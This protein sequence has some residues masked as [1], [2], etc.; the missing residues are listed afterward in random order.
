MSASFVAAGTTAVPVA[1]P[2]R[3]PA[4]FTITVEN[5]ADAREREALLDR[6]M[7]EGRTRKSS[8]KLRHQRLPAE[9]LALVARD[10]TGNM[11]GTVRLWHISAGEKSGYH[12]VPA[13]LLGPLA[14]EPSYA[15]RGVGSALMRQ[16]ISTA[17]LQGHKAILLVGDPEYYGRFGFQSEKTEHLAMPGPVERHR[18]LALELEEGHLNGA[19]GVLTA[20]GKIMPEQQAIV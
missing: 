19:S 20:T 6:V 14:I 1:G 5:A 16:A 3:T 12:P 15:G 4:L 9:G 2:T 13:L 17:R 10:E 18:F 11:I 8:E 7:G